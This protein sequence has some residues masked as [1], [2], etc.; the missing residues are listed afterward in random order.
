MIGRWARNPWVRAAIALAVI[1]GLLLGAGV[2]YRSYKLRQM[3]AL[4]DTVAQ[5]LQT[6][7]IEN[8]RLT[9]EDSFVLGNKPEWLNDQWVAIPTHT[10]AGKTLVF[11]LFVQHSAFGVRVATVEI[12]CMFHDPA[13]A[14]EFLAYPVEKNVGEVTVKHIPPAVLLDSG[15]VDLK[16]VLPGSFR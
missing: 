2:A 11:R 9:V 14:G 7:V 12:G 15:P 5:Q 4:G 10:P 6:N 13:V 3:E 8:N 16:T 1:S